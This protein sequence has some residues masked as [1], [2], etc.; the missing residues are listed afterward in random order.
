MLEQVE[1]G[2]QID[3]LKINVLQAL[4][5]IIKAWEEITAETIRNCWCHTN[6]LPVGIS[7]DLKSLSDHVHTAENAISDELCKVFEKI[8]LSESMEVEEFLSIPEED[9][10]Y[11]VPSDDQ[12]M[13]ELVDTFKIAESSNNS[14]DVDDS[15]EIAV[16]SAS[17][18]LQGLETVQAFLLQQENASEY[19]KMTNILE[20]YIREKKANAMRQTS[21]D[22]YFNQ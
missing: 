16:I 5:Y 4:Q 13:T 21:I 3:L 20:R 17:T 9:I 15:T 18:A 2:Q 19:V 8:H 6:I 1:A 22:Q 11:E 7:A 12:L 10:V 14:E